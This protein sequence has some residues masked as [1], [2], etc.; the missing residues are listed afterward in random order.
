MIA[1]FFIFQAVFKDCNW[2]WKMDSMQSTCG[3]DM[4]CFLILSFQ[5]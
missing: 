3:N 5:T 4:L 2:E 1:P